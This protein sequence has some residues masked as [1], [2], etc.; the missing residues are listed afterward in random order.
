MEDPGFQ[1]CGGA[2]S[3]AGA[4]RARKLLQADGRGAEVVGDGKRAVG[5][6][7]RLGGCPKHGLSSQRTDVF[8]QLRAPKVARDRAHDAARLVLKRPWHWEVELAA[9]GKVRCHKFV[10]PVLL[11]EVRTPRTGHLC[12]LAGPGFDARHAVERPGAGCSRV[13]PCRPDHREIPRLA[14]PSRGARPMHARPVGLHHRIIDLPARPEEHHA[15]VHGRHGPGESRCKLERPHG[16]SVVKEVINR[17]HEQRVRVQVQH[18][19]VLLQEPELELSPQ[20]RLQLWR[21]R[22][23]DL[24]GEEPALLQC[25]QGLQG[26]SRGSGASPQAEQD[27]QWQSAKFRTP[28]GGTP[29]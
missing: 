8:R 14:R 15:G 28:P 4:A 19:V 1:L 9:E 10:A 12:G 16:G 24:H 7:A 26:L 13:G 21:G 20:A 25:L 29:D 27:E 2:A 11:F 22:G 18:V 17:T 6:Q 3:F 23:Q 5:P